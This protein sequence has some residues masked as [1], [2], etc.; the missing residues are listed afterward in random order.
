MKIKISG[1][2][3]A[4]MGIFVFAVMVLPNQSEGFSVSGNILIDYGMIPPEGTVLHL[5]GQSTSIPSQQVSI[6]YTVQT[7]DGYYE[8]PDLLAGNY[9]VT[10][11]KSNCVFSDPSSRSYVDPISQSGQDFNGIYMVFTEGFVRDL[12]GN[13]ISNVAVTLTGGQPYY[14]SN[15]CITGSDGRYAFNLYPCMGYTLTPS[16]SGWSFLPV[17]VSFNSLGGPSCWDFTGRQRNTP[18]LLNLDM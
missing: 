13:G 3:L 9:T 18:S 17:N 5:Q 16:K 12:N 11:S 15:V 7:S 8:F 6:Y 1:T 14:C 2:I 10:P 4:I